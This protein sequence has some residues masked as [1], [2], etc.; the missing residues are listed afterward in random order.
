MPPTA[1]ARASPS[2]CATSS[3]C[4]T[5]LSP[6]SPRSS[7][8]SSSNTSA[9]ISRVFPNPRSQ[10][11]RKYPLRRRLNLL[12]RPPPDLL[13]NR[14]LVRRHPAHHRSLRRTPRREHEI[15]VV[16]H[17]PLVLKLGGLAIHRPHHLHL[18]PQ[19]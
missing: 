17:L 9:E 7:A 12:R 2:P 8:T 6:S 10:I 1:A 14:D 3:P 11:P 18:Q 5:S 4:K 16:P 13:H 19:F 15:H